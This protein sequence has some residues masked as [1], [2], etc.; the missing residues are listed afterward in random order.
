MRLLFGFC[1]ATNPRKPPNLR[2]CLLQ[3]VYS[4]AK[5]LSLRVL[6]IGFLLL[7]AATNIADGSTGLRVVGDP[8]F[9]ATA[10]QRIAAWLTSHGHQVMDDALGS[11]GGA[12][13]D[14]CYLGN[15]LKCASKT[16]VDNSKAELFLYVNFEVSSV[17]VRERTVKATLWLLK[18]TGS[19]DRW[20]QEC[21]RCDDDALEAMVDVLTKQIGNFRSRSGTMKLSS[22]PAGAAV[23]LDGESVGSTPVTVDVAPGA[24]QVVVTRSGY[25]AEQLTIEV[26][27]DAVVEKTIKLRT[28]GSDSSR[29]RRSAMVGSAALGA[30]AVVGGIIAGV[31][32]EGRSC[33]VTKKECLNTLPG[34]IVALASGGVLLG[35]AGY[36]WFTTEDSPHRVGFMDRRDSGKP[37]SRSYVVGWSRR[38]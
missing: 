33:E 25:L 28:V 5:M 24:H 20:E 2:A 26:T 12:Q 19:A 13:L 1:N 22:D 31:V 37:S 34:G 27:A 14:E 10:E 11:L 36:L 32:D 4:A 18:R 17:G 6:W 15:D 35:F 8:K 30:L 7:G 23:D 9:R 16:V 29:W 3:R 21:V 38:F